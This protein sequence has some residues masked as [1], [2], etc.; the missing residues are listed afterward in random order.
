MPGV[1]AV[2]ACTLIALLPELGQL[3]RRQIA[4]LVGVAPYA[5][6]SGKLKGARRIWGGRAPVR[7]GCRCGT[8][9][10]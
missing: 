8:A 3:G 2:L 10:S 7:C 1:G 9:G 5:F 4:A 6:D